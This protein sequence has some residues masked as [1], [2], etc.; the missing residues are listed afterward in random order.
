MSDKSGLDFVLERESQ[1]PL[2]SRVDPA[3]FREKLSA[4]L[5]RQRQEGAAEALR[6]ERVKRSQ[7]MEF[8][9]QVAVHAGAAH[10]LRCKTSV[11][12][13]ICWRC[14]TEPASNNPYRVCVRCVD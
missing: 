4:Q 8:Q 14:H 7:L 5:Q 3:T 10:L 12:R 13:G 11:A 2:T 6:Q 1:H 9:G